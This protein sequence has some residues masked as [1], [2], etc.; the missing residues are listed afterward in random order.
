MANPPARLTAVAVW[1]S[2]VLLACSSEPGPPGG[3]A[4][5]SVNADG[6]TGDAG[7]PGNYFPK[8]VSAHGVRDFLAEG[9]HYAEGWVVDVASPR[10]PEPASPHEDVR[11]F[12]N[13]TLKAS[14]EAGNGAWDGGV[15]VGGPHEVGSMAVK[16]MYDVTAADGGAPL[17][18]RAAILKTEAGD[19]QTAWTYFCIGPSDRC[20]GQ[21]GTESKPIFGNGANLFLCHSCHAGNIFTSPP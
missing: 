9:P 21:E 14:I 7:V 3:A 18:A 13:P 1:L 2:S 4:D 20:A 12:F 5:A 19:E 15:R 6:G 8:T 17:V 11:V 10:P 16:E